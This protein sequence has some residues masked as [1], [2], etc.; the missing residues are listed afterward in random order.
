MPR[1]VDD[2]LVQEVARRIL[3]VVRP[4]RIILFGSAASGQ[5]SDDSDLDILVLETRTGNTRDERVRISDALRGLGFSCD[6]FVMQTE[7]FEESKDVIGGLAYPANRYG[8][9][10]YEAA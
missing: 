9:V 7:N 2:E 4:D 8:R 3:T 6:V 1:V 10:I 5:L